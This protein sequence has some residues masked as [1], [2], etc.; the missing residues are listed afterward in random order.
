MTTSRPITSPRPTVLTVGR[1]PA[2]DVQLA[3]PLVSRWHARIDV[4]TE[5]VLSDLHSFRG[6]QVNA[7]TVNGSCSLLEGDV[8]SVGNHR[9]AWKGGRLVTAPAVSTAVLVADTLSTVTANGKQLLRDVSLQLPSGSLT[10][11]IGPSGAG[12]STLLGALTGLRPASHGRVA[13]RGADLYE[14][15]DELKYTIGVVPQQDIQHPQLTVEQALGFAAQLRLPPDTTPEERTARVRAVAARLQLADRMGNRIGTQLSGGQRKRV[16]IATELLTAPPLLFLDEPTSGL[17]PGLDVEIMRQLR[18]LAAE[19]RVVVVVTHSVLALD[20]CDTVVALAPGGWVAFSGPPSSLLEHFGCST[21]PE[22]FDLLDRRSVTATSPPDPASARPVVRRSLAGKRPFTDAPPHVMRL[23]FETLL[24]RNVAVIAADRLLLGMLVAMPLVLGILSRL[25]PGESGLS[26][27]D[28]PRSPGGML[29][30]EEA[31]KRLTLL[32]VAAAL[33]GVA[34]TVREL[35][36][37]RPIFQREHA[38]GLSADVYLASKITVLG[39]AAVGQGL[40]VTGLAAVAMPGPDFG[41]D[42]HLGTVEIALTIALLTFSMAVVGLGLSAV[43]TSVEQTMPALVAA[44][45]VQVV[46]SGA[47]IEVAGRP[48]L[49]P[50]SWLTPARWAYAASASSM[51]LQ[52]PRWAQGLDIDWIAIH[53]FGHWVMNLMMLMALTVAFAWLGLLAVRRSARLR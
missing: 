8:V 29:N 9:L 51:S 19:G 28:A 18:G 15:Y 6:T 45:M 50:L 1:D 27:I 7:R 21:Y 24:R 52:R 37:E 31:G 30:V 34:M 12:K 44:V 5:V 43:V 32:V 33:M 49:A 36:A 40:V 3:D 17:D 16:S 22:V 53:G 23:Q 38:V 48:F 42:L 10:A 14:H 25:V 26:L 20:T 4:G 41:G 39:L 13:Y 11:I 2:N 47:L 46:L 35:V